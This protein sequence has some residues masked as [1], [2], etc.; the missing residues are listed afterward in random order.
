VADER[1]TLSGS[2]RSISGR[3]YVLLGNY[4]TP[5]NGT[6]VV[7]EGHVEINIA[8]ILSLLEILAERIG[9]PMGID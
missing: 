4:I 1:A 6:S 3:A 7:E 8:N 2:E 9:V 5:F